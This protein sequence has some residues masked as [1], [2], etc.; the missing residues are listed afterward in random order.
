M[1]QYEPL[2]RFI[3]A[4]A[5]V[6]IGAMHFIS[7]APHVKIVPSV[8]PHPLALVYIGGLIEILAG[9][10]FGLLIPRFSRAAAWV[11]VILYDEFGGLKE[12]AKFLHYFCP[13]RVPFHPQA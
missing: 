10:G 1:Q 7:P 5:M 6:A 11:L 13:D 12:A 8:L 2:F 9:V 3:F 4:L